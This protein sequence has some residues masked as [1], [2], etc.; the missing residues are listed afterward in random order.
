MITSEVVLVLVFLNTFTFLLLYCTRLKFY[1]VS[2]A[3]FFVSKLVIIF[4]SRVERALK[5]LIV[6]VNSKAHFAH[7]DEYKGSLDA[8]AKA[9]S[10]SA[11]NMLEK[12]VMEKE[13]KFVAFAEEV[14]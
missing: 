3:G 2:L 8:S 10:V 11:T 1:G 7:Q 12:L 14:Q 6:T 5:E 13:L 9:R 4:Y